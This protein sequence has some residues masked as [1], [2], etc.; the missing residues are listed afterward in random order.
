MN[1]NEL[2]ISSR[3]NVLIGVAV[4]IFAML[5][6]VNWV[7]LSK[8]GA[9]QKE[10]QRRTQEAGQLKHDAGLGAEAYRVVADTVINRQF[11]DVAKKW[12][13]ISIEVDA[14]LDFAAKA[15]D[16][17]QERQWAAEARK[18]MTDMRTLYA[19]SFL[20]MV[21]RDAPLSEIAVVD[22]QVDKLIDKYDEL[23]TK[24]ATSL[25][26]EA[27]G[28]T[29][30]FDAGV[31]TTRT[32]NIASVG[33][34]ALLLVVLALLVSR[35]ITAQLGM[36]L[37][38]AITEA[39]HVAA[40]DLT[41]MKASGSHTPESLAG[42]LDAM[43]VTLVNTVS[44]VRRGAEGVSTASAEI[45]S[46][47]HDLSARTESQASALEETAASM[48]QLSA[49]VKQNADSARQANQLAASASTV[50]V[51][52][53]E[54]VAKV[55]DTMKGINDASRKIADII[56]VIDGIAFQT[57]ILALNA[58]V[59]A[60]RAGEQGRGFA[61]VAS[62]VRSLAGRSAEAAKEIKTLI[63]ASVEQVEQG[64]A[65]VDQAGSTMTE[66]VSSI[67]R[68][69]D[70]MGEI[71]AASNEQAAGVSQVGEA[72]T[73]MDQVTQQN[74]ALVEEMAAA[75]SSLKSQAE[76]LVQVVAVFNL[77][78]NSAQHSMAP[79]PATVRVPASNTKTYKS[80]ERRALAAPTKAAAPAK[81]GD[82]DWETF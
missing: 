14:A 34:G 16:T 69:T 77:G 58:A 38:E 8:L 64:T 25:Q 4:L 9:L 63:N 28:A 6:A 81:A 7:S 46:G 17:D 21:K 57:N 20:P 51:K 39:Q 78:G 41:Q 35:S 24:G 67:K 32:I 56:S 80:P 82:D 11:D 79:R 10:S 52:G 12:S 68:V 44:S 76:D 43:L 1:F 48:E 33:V 3:L 42:A 19:Q 29:A 53:G 60:A 36:E 59:E 23:I 55:V 22:D 50:A 2:K 30:A 70:L 47:N 62:E 15:A 65:L 75:A 27:D 73:Q 5:V 45:A 49:T 54:V 31:S 61:V 40:G 37:D 72:V 18:A 74:A 66:V 13:A 71:S 26:A